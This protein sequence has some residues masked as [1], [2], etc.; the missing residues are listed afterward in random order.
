[1]TLVQAICMVHITTIIIT[2]IIMEQRMAKREKKG[3]NKKR[4]IK[5]SFDAI[6]F[7]NCLGRTT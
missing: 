7:I 4:D 5:I 2:I 1:M 6:F 3:E